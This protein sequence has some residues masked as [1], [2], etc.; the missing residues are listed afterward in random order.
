MTIIWRSGG[1]AFMDLLVAPGTL[2]FLLK[3]DKSPHF[4]NSGPLFAPVLPTAGELAAE[5]ILV[6]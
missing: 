4:G 1:G 6:F 5:G 2:P 3:P